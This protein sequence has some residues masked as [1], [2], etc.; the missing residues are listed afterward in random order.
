MSA[1]CSAVGS[2]LTAQS[3]KTTT[4]SG[5]HMKKH[6]DARAMPGAHLMICRAGL[7]VCAVVCTAPE[8]RPSALPS[9]T[10]KVPGMMVSARASRACSGVRPFFLRNSHRIGI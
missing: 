6:E 9:L 4:W 7:M 5:R 3:A 10:I 1:S 2:G 8:T